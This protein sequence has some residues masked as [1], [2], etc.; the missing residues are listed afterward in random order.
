MGFWCRHHF[1]LRK[2]ILSARNLRINL[3]SDKPEEKQTKVLIQ[4]QL[5]AILRL[6]G[7]SLRRH[8]LVTPFGWQ[9]ASAN[10]R[11]LLVLTLGWNPR[12]SFCVSR[13]ALSSGP[14]G[15]T[16]WNPSSSNPCWVSIRNTRQ[17]LTCSSALWMRHGVEN[18]H[19]WRDSR[20]L[21]A[22]IYLSGFCNLVRFA[23]LKDFYLVLMLLLGW[24]YINCVLRYNQPQKHCFPMQ[25]KRNVWQIPCF[26]EQVRKKQIIQYFLIYLLVPSSFFLFCSFP[27]F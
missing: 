20:M 25:I 18:M 14:D 2:A 4:H 5:I 27:D 26:R 24:D 6:K 1:P 9:W 15:Y 3:P 17:H 8:R 22:A 13:K 21:Q 7:N 11:S 10:V 12:T 23:R 19:V 16:W